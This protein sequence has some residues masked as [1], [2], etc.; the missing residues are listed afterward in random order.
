MRNA[1]LVP[2]VSIDA[3]VMKRDGMV[4]R[5]RKA[6]LLFLEADELARA[7][8]AEEDGYQYHRINLLSRDHRHDFVDGDGL[9]D[10]IKGID[11]RI[12]SY[13]LRESGMRSLM[14]A[15]ARA[16]WDKAIEKGDVPAITRESI[17]ATFGALYDG[18]REMFERGV[19]AIFRSLSW[20]YKTNSPVMFGK[21]LVLRRIADAWGP[22]YDGCNRL[23]DLIRVMSILDGR[24]E[25][26]YRQGCNRRM[27]EAR[28]PKENNP[29][30]LG[31]FTVRGFKNGNG[32]L[33]FTRADLVEKMNGILAR[34]YPGALPASREAA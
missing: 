13:L 30:D 4:E 6:H 34:H 28:W 21:R 27:H 24:P 3:I 33:T 10:L 32:H 1:E 18:R 17:A 11:A 15:T 8:F 22:N 20:D 9:A 26:D 31:Y 14:D 25:P 2:S 29:L 5:V 12:W 23:D 16:E 19:I 7:L